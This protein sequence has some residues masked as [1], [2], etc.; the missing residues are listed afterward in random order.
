MRL[1]QIQSGANNRE[2][3]TSPS[4]A[5]CARTSALQVNRQE[6]IKTAVIDNQDRFLSRSTTFDVP[7]STYFVAAEERIHNIETHLG[8]LTA[9]CDKGLFERI[10][11]LEDK[12][13]KIEQQYPQIAAHC[14]NYGQ[15][16]REASRRP[17]GRVSNPDQKAKIKIRVPPSMD[18]TKV[19]EIQEKM[20][21]LKKRLSKK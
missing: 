6:H 5:G 20:L 10:K 2:E 19:Q 3:F 1:Q 16:E 4:E 9:P 7:E 14:F 17:G 11:I 13:L 8:I 18:T 15:V 21:N 12:I